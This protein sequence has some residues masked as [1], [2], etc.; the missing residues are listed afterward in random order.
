MVDMHAAF[1]IVI[2]TQSYLSAATAKAPLAGEA[3]SHAEFE[4]TAN[5]GS[6]AALQMQRM[7]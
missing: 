4:S 7:C 1:V 3:L 5:S 6:W 2:G